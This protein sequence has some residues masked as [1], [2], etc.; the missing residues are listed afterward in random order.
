M[1]FFWIGS[2]FPPTWFLGHFSHNSCSCVHL[3]VSDVNT[4]VGAFLIIVLPLKSFLLHRYG[5][6]LSKQWW[7]PQ[8][9]IFFSFLEE[10]DFVVGSQG[11]HPLCPLVTHLA[12]SL[13]ARK[14]CTLHLHMACSINVP[15][16]KISNA[17]T[18]IH[19][20]CNSSINGYIY[21]STFS[22]FTNFFPRIIRVSIKKYRLV[23]NQVIIQ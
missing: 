3:I 4:H 11:G 20:T 10:R 17:W 8:Y 21:T 18:P 23:A 1:P 7:L 16:E 12:N 19:R 13:N 2:N 22:T 14:S 15:L 5:W 9:M 6:F